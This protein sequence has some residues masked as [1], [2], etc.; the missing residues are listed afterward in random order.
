MAEAE[1]LACTDP[2]P[3]EKI[4]R[5]KVSY[6]KLGL[7]DFAW[8]E[9]WSSLRD[10]RLQRAMEIAVRHV[11]LETSDEQLAAAQAEVKEVKRLFACAFMRDIAGNP[12]HETPA[13]LP[14]WLTWNDATIPRMA[15]LI[16]DEQRF[17]DIPILADALMD[18]GCHDTEI[19]DH[20]RNEGMHV[21]GFWVVDLV[22]GKS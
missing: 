4:F 13:I 14:A 19:L 12:F 16:Y 8:V 15:Q 6:R 20:C 18:A 21:R 10:P 11:R 17:E 22:L 3:M 7:F 2:K 5:K 1:W 9:V